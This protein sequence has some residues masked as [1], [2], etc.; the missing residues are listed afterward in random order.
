MMKSFWGTFIKGFVTV[1]PL[2]I[3]LYLVFWIIVSAEAM[4]G[5]LLKM[6]LSEKLYIPGMGIAGGIVLLYMLGLLME[7]QMVVRK[8]S[9]FAE[10]QVERIPVLKSFYSSLKNLMNFITA[11]KEEKGDLRR[12][13]VV[14]L[15]DDLHLIGFVTG[16]AQ[17]HLGYSPDNDEK[18]LAVYIPMSYQ[19]GGYTVYLP[20]SRLTTLDMGFEEATQLVLTAGVGKKKRQSEK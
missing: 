11:A 9:D 13:V 5:G 19:V 2:V 12:V 20:Q 4:V 17:D 8:L 1:I 14:H 18:T 6:I 15:T 10:R 3:T 7:K 16:D